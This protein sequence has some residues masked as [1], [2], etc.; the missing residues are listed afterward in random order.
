ME[1]AVSGKFISRT[2]RPYSGF[3]D[4]QG[5]QRP[6]GV[7][8]TF[9]IVQDELTAPVQI[10]IKQGDDLTYEKVSRVA[11]GTLLH[12][13][14]DAY[15]NGNRITLTARSVEAPAPVKS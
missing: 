10:K 3:T 13:V 4:G 1:Q 2:E 9:W 8:R 6:G 7:S 11:F 5:E 12:V 14:C 15:A